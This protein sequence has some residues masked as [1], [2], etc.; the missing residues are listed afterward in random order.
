MRDLAYEIHLADS[1]VTDLCAAFDHD[2][3]TVAHHV[4]EVE[5]I[6]SKIVGLTFAMRLVRT[7][8]AA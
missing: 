5:E 2:P 6:Y 1:I 3:Q 7:M 4:Q 8:E